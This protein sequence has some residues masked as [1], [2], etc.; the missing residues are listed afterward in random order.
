MLSLLDFLNLLSLFF[1]FC[2]FCFLNFSHFLSSLLQDADDVP[3]AS[4]L[5]VDLFTPLIKRSLASASM[6]KPHPAS[7]EDLVQNEVITMLLSRDKGNTVD[8]SVAQAMVLHELDKSMAP[9][10]A[11]LSEEKKMLF[12]PSESKWYEVS[13]EALGPKQAVEAYTAEFEAIRQQIAKEN[14][15]AQKFEQKIETV[16]KM[17]KVRIQLKH[18]FT[19]VHP[20][21]LI[22]LFLKAGF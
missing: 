12:V 15:R 13:D 17:H 9:E 2:L 11:G 20:R 14:K 8:T 1:F 22:I 10:E 21:K 16:I 3:A 5:E 6:L 18:Q 7:A 19:R 4:S